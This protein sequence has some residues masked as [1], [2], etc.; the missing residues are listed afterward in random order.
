[1]SGRF[2]KGPSRKEVTGYDNNRNDER[3][4]N[5]DEIHSI[6]HESLKKYLEESEVIESLLV[7][8]VSG[9]YYNNSY[10]KEATP[11]LQ[12]AIKTMDIQKDCEEIKDKLVEIIK[13]DSENIIKKL[14]SEAI[15]K[16]LS[17]IIA[18]SYELNEIIRASIMSA[19][20]PERR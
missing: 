13:N 14:I 8:K 15:S 16:Q 1:M 12:G 3:K 10:R 11:L 17:Q 9:N 7:Q 2:L 6:I 5:K 19:M 18:S 20:N 4:T